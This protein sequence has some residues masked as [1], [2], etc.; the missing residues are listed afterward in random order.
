[1]IR[2]EGQA[3]TKKVYSAGSPAE[4][5]A[6]LQDIRNRYGFSKYDSWVEG[7]DV[8]VSIEKNSVDD[9]EFYDMSDNV[10][11]YSN[12]MVAEK[13]RSRKITISESQLRLLIS[14][15]VKNLLK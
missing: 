1:M 2:E 13:K 6:A 12:K 11:A 4:A 7:N 5:L 3:T 9:F 10:D 15:G 8:Y 14:A